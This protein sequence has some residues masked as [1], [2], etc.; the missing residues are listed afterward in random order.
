[1][2]TLYYKPNCSFYNAFC[3]MAENLKVEFDLKDVSEDRDSNG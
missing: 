3:K 1:M 2:L